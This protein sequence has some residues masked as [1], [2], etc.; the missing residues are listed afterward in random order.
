[1]MEME[2]RVDE[3]YVGPD[4]FFDPSLVAAKS[5]YESEAQETDLYQWM[6]GKK[7]ASDKSELSAYVREAE[8]L[9][10]PDGI[11][12][13]D[14]MTPFTPDGGQYGG[15]KD[16]RTGE[17]DLQTKAKEIRKIAPFYCAIADESQQAY[18]TLCNRET[19]ARIGMTADQYR[20]AGSRDRFVKFQKNGFF[21]TPEIAE[22]KFKTWLDGNDLTQMLTLGKNR[23]L[24]EYDD[25]Q[26]SAVLPDGRHHSEFVGTDITAANANML[27]NGIPAGMMI[28]NGKLGKYEN[29]TNG[30][31]TVDGKQYRLVSK[32]AD[33]NRLIEP[34][35][36]AE[37][38]SRLKGL[39][40]GREWG[41]YEEHK[42]HDFD[43]TNEIHADALRYAL[44]TTGCKNEQEFA[45]MVYESG[46]R[47]LDVN[48]DTFF[49]RQTKD[50]FKLE[51]A[52]DS[53]SYCIA[54]LNAL[55][56][57]KIL[58]ERNALRAMH[59]R[60]MLKA[61]PDIVPMY[62][63]YNDSRIK[64]TSVSEND[65]VFGRKG[66]TER[67][68]AD[69]MAYVGPYMK[70]DNQLTDEERKVRD[71]R[72]ANV[73]QLMNI[74]AMEDK[75]VGFIHG[76]NVV[77]RIT[78]G[79]SNT[80][81]EGG[82]ELW[83]LGVNGVKNFGG[84]Q[85]IRDALFDSQG[86]TGDEDVR[87]HFKSWID[88]DLEAVTS[89]E[90]MNQGTMI[91][92]VL[93]EAGKLLAFSYFMRAASIGNLT[94][95]S[96]KA[97]EVAG[98]TMRNIRYGN[99]ESYGVRVAESGRKIQAWGRANFG[100]KITNTTVT[101]WSGK[102]NPPKNAIKLGEDWYVP[103]TEKV[104]VGRAA[105]MSES[106]IA[107]ARDRVAKL[108]AQASVAEQDLM[109][110]SG[111]VAP[112]I[113]SVNAT[114]TQLT[115]AEKA[116]NAAEAEIAKAIDARKFYQLKSWAMDI[117]NESPAILGVVGSQAMAHKNAG[118]YKLGEVYAENGFD[119]DLLKP[120]NEYA[121][122]DAYGNA[123]FMMRVSKLVGGLA[124]AKYGTAKAQAAAR[125]VMQEIYTACAEGRYNEASAIQ[126]LLDSAY[127]R[128][129]F[130]WLKRKAQT[131]VHGAALGGA[132]GSL[133]VGV[134]SRENEAL[135]LG[136]DVTVDQGIEVL[137]G[138]ARMGAGTAVVGAAGDVAHPS[139][140][141]REFSDAVN[142]VKAFKAIDTIGREQW[143]TAIGMGHRTGK[144]IIDADQ[145]SANPEIAMR[146]VEKQLQKEKGEYDSV[147][148]DVTKYIDRM[149]EFA[150]GRATGYDVGDFNKFRDEVRGKYGE[151]F[152]R[153]V[154]SVGKQ[155][156]NR[157]D[158]LERFVESDYEQ[159]RSM[160]AAERIGEGKR[161]EDY[162]KRE[163]LN[164][165]R[166]G[167]GADVKPPVTM[168][169]G[170]QRFEIGVGGKYVSFSVRSGEI[171]YKND[172]GTFEHGWASE[173]VD[174]LEKGIDGFDEAHG[175]GEVIAALKS[176]DESTKELIKQ[177]ID[178]GGLLT[179]AE[180]QISKN[181]GG[182]TGL[183]LH[184]EKGR[185][186]IKM[187]SKRDDITSHDISHEGA[188]GVVEMMRANGALTTNSE[189]TGTE[190]ILRRHYGNSDTWEDLFIADMMSMKDE[191][192]LRGLANEAVA[193]ASGRTKL[194]RFFDV[195][196]RI[197]AFA[198]APSYPKRARVSDVEKAIYAKLNEARKAMADE[199]IDDGAKDLSEK[200]DEK[201]GQQID[202]TKMA[203]MV[204]NQPV[205][206]ELMMS[207]VKPE[208]VEA[209]K[210][211]LNASG[212]YYDSTHDVWVNEFSAPTLYHRAVNDV[213]AQKQS[214][215]MTNIKE[216]F[217][218]IRT[219]PKFEAEM[220]K[221]TEKLAKIRKLVTP[222]E[223]TE[224]ER[225][226][227]GIL[228]AD[229]GEPLGIV[230][231]NDGFLIDI[232]GGYSLV[233]GKNFP[234]GSRIVP[235]QHDLH[236]RWNVKA[237]A[238]NSNLIAP[239]CLSPKW[240]IKML[241]EGE[242]AGLSLG[243]QPK[244]QL[245]NNSFGVVTFLFG[246]KSIDLKVKDD[247]GRYLN[248][249]FDR[250][251]GLPTYG[252]IYNVDKNG[253]VVRNRMQGYDQEWA[254]ALNPD[255]SLRRYETPSEVAEGFAYWM[256]IDYEQY[257]SRAVRRARIKNIERLRAMIGRD[258]N[259]STDPDLVEFKRDGQMPYLYGEAKLARLVSAGEII[260]VSIPRFSEEYK[261]MHS[262]KIE[263]LDKV[264]VAEVAKKLGVGVDMFETILKKDLYSG[265][266]LSQKFEGKPLHEVVVKSVDAQDGFFSSLDRIAELC[267][268]R[269][270]P[271]DYW[272][273][274]GI[275]FNKVTIGGGLDAHGLRAESIDRLSEKR[276]EI[277]FN[278]IGKRGAARYF[279]KAWNEV[280]EQIRVIVEDAITGVDEGT[281][282]GLRSSKN[283]EL[284]KFIAG[285]N[286]VGEFLVHIGGT[287]GDKAVRLEY[288][289]RK[290]KVPQ[291]FLKRSSTEQFH[292]YDFM[293]NA[294]RQDEVLA[295]AY[296]EIMNAPIYFSGTKKASELGVKEPAWL[297]DNIFIL[298]NE[299]GQIVIRRDRWNERLVPEQF[300]QA[301]VGLIQAEEG[302][303]QRIRTSDVNVAKALVPDRAKRMNSGLAFWL[304]DSRMAIPPRMV[305]GIVT[306]ERV[307]P[308]IE[309]ALK[310]R[311]GEKYD[312]AIVSR[313][314]K[315]IFDS[316]KASVK[317]FAGEAEARFLASRFGMKE[318]ELADYS[319]AEEALK[320]TLVTL[321]S[322][323]TSAQ[324]TKKNLEYWDNVIIKA[325]D[326]AIFGR[327]NANTKS[328]DGEKR[329]YTIRPEFREAV[330]DEILSTIIHNILSGTRAVRRL[331]E[332]KITGIGVGEKAERVMNLNEG[333]SSVSSGEP[334][335]DEKSESGRL[336]AGFAMMNGEDGWD[337]SSGG[338]TLVTSEMS[339][340]SAVDAGVTSEVKSI[341][342]RWERNKS[343][344]VK[345]VREVVAKVKAELVEDASKAASVQGKLMDKLY[346]LV[347]E[348]SST[349]DPVILKSMLNEAIT[350][351]GGKFKVVGARK[352][353]KDFVVEAASARLARAIL[354]EGRE[355]KV[356]DRTFRDIN[357]MAT[358]IGVKSVDR[359]AFVNE[360]FDAA[361]AIAEGIVEK[362]KKNGEID[363]GL[364]KES[365]KR[366][367]IHQIA[368]KTMSSFLGG[369]RAGAMSEGS[370]ASAVME[371]KRIQVRNIKDA[372]GIKLAELNSMLG[373]DICGDIENLKDR[374]GS[375]D[376]LA[377]ETIKRFA[378]RLRATD[379]KFTGMTDEE[380]TNDPVARQM[381]ASTVGGWL[382]ETARRLGWGRVREWAMN[383][384]QRIRKEPPT[385]G[386]LHQI[387]AKHADRLAATIGQ[388]NVNKLLDS[389]DKFIDESADGS[390]KARADIPNY[391][392]LVAPRLQDYWNF[393]KKAMRMTEAEVNKQIAHYQNELELSDRQMLELSEKN[394]SDIDANEELIA[395]D[396]AVMRL[397]ALSRYGNLRDKTYAEVRDIFDN[398][399]ARDISGEALRYAVRRA[400]R[401]AN[402]AKIR[403]AFIGELTAIRNAKKGE[404]DKNDNGTAA[405]NF[406]SFS[407]ADLFKR[408]SLYLHEG[409]DSWKFIDSFRQDMSL[410][411]IDKTMFVSKWEGEMRKACQR[412]YGVNFEKLV[413]DM[414]VKNPEY[415]KFSRGGWIIPADGEVVEVSTGRGKKNVVKAV[416]NDGSQPNNLPNHL[417]KAN[418]IY[419]YAACQQADMQV[420]NVIYG[421]DERYFKEIEDII[422]PEGVAM[423]QWL[424]SA[425]GEI[426]KAISPICEEITGMQVLSPDE[427]YCPLSFIKDEV[428]N[429]ERRYSSSPFPA[430]LTRR[431]THDSLRLNEQCDAFRTFEDK[432]Q[433]S[434]HYIGFARIIDRMN[435]TLKH[436]KVQT[437]YAHLYGTK[438]K[439]DIY[440][441]LADALNGGR[442]SSDTL[443]SGVRNFVTATSLFGNIGSALKQ[444]EGIGGWAVEMGLK[445]W[446][447]GLVRN[448]VTS[449][450][451]RQ[452]IR[453]L[454]DAGLFK[455]RV[456]EGISEAMVALMN[457]CDG[458]PEGPM[459]RTYSWY[460]RHGMD[461]TK[462]VDKIASMSMAGQYYVGR[463]NFYLEHGMVEEVAKRKAL[464]DTDYAIQT[465]QQS[466]RPEFLHNQQRAGTAGRLITQFSGPAFVRWGIECESWHRAM[467]M[468]DKGAFT[469]LASRLIALHVI[470][471][472]ILALAGGV[473]AIMF[474][475]DDQKLE[476]LVE[477]TY[478]DI[479]VNCI[480]GPM[481]GWFIWGQLINAGVN[482]TVMPD[483]GSKV[484]ARYEAPALAKLNSL[485]QMTSKMYNDVQKAAPWDFFS[486]REKELISE[487]ALRILEMIMPVT[488]IVE[489]LRR[490]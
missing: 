154:E 129:S 350:M 74:L 200:L 287:D 412:I 124:Q 456:E 202:T 226:H 153:M 40:S 87:S 351:T 230:N 397:N 19:G 5:D 319:K 144:R 56:E 18:E 437:A 156:R 289:G 47:T 393:V 479:A 139:V 83:N 88:S 62:K 29:N 15:V 34:Y 265:K 458:V 68:S 427:N 168:A 165:F 263:E 416:P 485:M 217:R 216:A 425:Y 487:D 409:S 8:R 404:A 252:D 12:F 450:E 1:M 104:V 318:N 451:V 105:P 402:D 460:K 335:A 325:V 322:D 174:K 100:G 171:S 51:L 305:D 299:D 137:K 304:S 128:G 182:E 380:F 411:N 123:L 394:P 449:A 205:P 471:P 177:G 180:A 468:G 454:I 187:S 477:R 414:M 399:I 293:G 280:D 23:K 340:V 388:N 167:L 70:P 431:V 92:L 373:S 162:S 453:E 253:N 112:N 59:I 192:I 366:A 173:V 398:D 462:F 267:E 189:G 175:F 67:L 49:A 464:A 240:A 361:K 484:K 486:Q 302:W 298:P 186:V 332:E 163:V 22:G 261:T 57:D 472:S 271:V 426:R 102:G 262:Q 107:E 372:R 269:G 28:V 291:G 218:L 264:A 421:R 32:D 138:M 211:Q 473:S 132:M 312:N 120:V 268:R 255:R 354:R 407:V 220:L 317:N 116:I 199:R 125:G 345:A 115:E 135:G 413:L 94:A 379:D 383:E 282:A 242:S 111:D 110:M 36:L 281:R 246:K 489:P 142:R 352:T 155:F 436:P 259:I 95:K 20:N 27:R 410:A 320:N 326:V 201:L 294:V 79:V 356:Y 307:G 9:F 258:G 297:D 321:D 441:Q 266:Y 134:E 364:I 11:K 31:V 238:N 254:V 478:K 113:E 103:K 207:G 41:D 272:D 84:W 44:S 422:G 445:D 355:Q 229:N 286:K 452:G 126:H 76:G 80:V 231:V 147:R 358:K 424:T 314:G 469:K 198:T 245:H 342:A 223:F 17:L 63:R 438:A 290:P 279:G 61:T 39:V 181:G 363:E 149:I 443:L 249:L 99:V 296:P 101:K 16:F 343:K 387:M 260:G 215:Q 341:D 45:K 14:G 360:V 206:N 391:E 71:E 461:I 470:C 376:K 208:D 3:I 339:V 239:H 232:D 54:E 417:S 359:T 38:G 336:A 276:P 109:A 300:A 106:K 214:R 295:K 130:N 188:H 444:L 96:G 390:K 85:Q 375:G 465:T 315:A 2:N 248:Y 233:N 209:R 193:D 143:L 378:D 140:G 152:A 65:Y 60:M 309:K 133:A 148:A 311:L 419:I 447:L 81:A 448:P 203:V 382:I 371:A 467:V 224:S 191:A 434:G 131:F 333:S 185:R 212:F 346:K 86:T 234:A 164:A 237:V 58:N 89:G 114:F 481:S 151:T 377:A 37:D 108:N 455:T 277:L 33:G 241:E 197:S 270:I 395:R 433:D 122:W 324:Q 475:R 146:Q 170:S 150:A 69:I 169:D 227:M 127:V 159:R 235:Y 53:D 30:A 386:M 430:F 121:V 257:P 183:F 308:I 288:A 285:K 370:E 66:D 476:D 440:A 42:W 82:S 310:E 160:L 490:K 273:G 247:D 344:V 328:R 408:M 353:P 4:T 401:L 368:E 97:L 423:A 365:E 389:I 118:A 384:A 374:F 403:Q 244:G 136:A 35:F 283:A 219:L 362:Q 158:W 24:N 48:G 119:A 184:D 176:I 369:Y 210:A 446:V 55:A 331:S 194:R 292:V 278:V 367:A 228:L 256:D 250:D 482:A 420:N 179:K 483:V 463:R 46:G 323:L 161:F 91:G 429:D 396:R 442:K 213:I 488:R 406:L 190:D 306:Y 6:M 313:V 77:S 349:D 381:L 251:M 222:E 275:D 7:E 330:A 204:S 90:L 93:G 141:F 301:I 466:G 196:K 334:E 459:S 72:V 405:G 225:K 474:R 400:E 52:D 78:A 439:N 13:E 432:I 43:R 236:L 303:E 178:V 385:F 25:S 64:N 435:S 157:S 428:S 480:T 166:D 274:D 21:S 392:R 10:C 50:G 337:A 195:L 316:I 457:S 338:R 418:L 243:V 172:N 329:W 75:R 73:N 117:A 327:H 357:D 145:L 347:K 284:N 26:V 415:D 348:N 98:K 221:Q